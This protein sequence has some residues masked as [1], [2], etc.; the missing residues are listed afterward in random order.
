VPLEL[1]QAI[2][3]SGGGGEMSP[4]APLFDGSTPVVRQAEAMGF[5]GAQQ[6]LEA[7]PYALLI[8]NED[9]VIATANSNA[10]RMFGLPQSAL[11][12]LS[13]DQLLPPRLRDAHQVYRRLYQERPRARAMQK[14]PYLWAV[15]A[16][17]D[18]FCV[19]VQ[20]TPITMAGSTWVVAAIRELEPVAE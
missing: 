11:A 8:A 5:V 1:N 19:Q 12:G 9:G 4:R 17:G 16:G 15:R 20:L 18:E 7:S 6:M 13:V 2:A 10:S 3:A 14:Y